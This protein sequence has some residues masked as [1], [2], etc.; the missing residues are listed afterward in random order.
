MAAS[1]CLNGIYTIS[2]ACRVDLKVPFAVTGYICDFQK[3]TVCFLKSVHGF[4]NKNKISECY[5][6]GLCSATKIG[7]IKCI[8]IV[9]LFC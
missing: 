8:F 6:H 9:H 2:V 3:K 7:N 5:F 1:L 4:S